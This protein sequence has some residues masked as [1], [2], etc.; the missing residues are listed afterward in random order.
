MVP[1]E[2]SGSVRHHTELL[3]SCPQPSTSNAW[4]RLDIAYYIDR[5]GKA[6]R[7]QFLSLR[8][9]RPLKE[10]ATCQDQK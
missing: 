2:S 7:G 6:S 3:Y 5:K 4:K 8:P 1:I 9:K 10:R